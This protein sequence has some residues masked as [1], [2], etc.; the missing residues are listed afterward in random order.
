M[1]G[2]Y[3]LNA[4]VPYSLMDLWALACLLPVCFWFTHKER[5]HSSL[6]EFFLASV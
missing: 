3:V 6:A 2:F 1:L 4:F 5:L